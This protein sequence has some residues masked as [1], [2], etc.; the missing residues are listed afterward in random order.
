M[1]GPMPS[2]TYT[3]TTAPNE[4]TSWEHLEKGKTYRVAIEFTDTDRDIHPEGEEWTFLGYSHNRFDD[5]LS[6]FVTFDGNQEWHIPLQYPE[7]AGVLDG[8]GYYMVP[9]KEL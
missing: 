6:L 9:V 4:G 8:L 7:Q 1:I 3:S 2:G 5:A